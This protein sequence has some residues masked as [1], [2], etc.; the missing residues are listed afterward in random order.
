MST[1]SPGDGRRSFGR[2]SL[3]R[4]LGRGGMG[5]V[6]LADA[7]ALDGVVKR[8]ALKLI[9]L[10]QDG[11]Q[12]FEREARHSML[13]SHSNIVSV[14]DAGTQGSTG[15]LAMEW[16]DGIDLDH[17]CTVLGARTSPPFPEHVALFIVH[18]VLRALDHAHH[19]G[20]GAGRVE[21]VHRDV[22]T[23]NI[24]VSRDGDVK[25]T[26]FGIARSRLY[27]ATSDGIVR[28]KLR[29]M[30]PEQLHGR[31]VDPRTDL[32]GVGVVLHEL[33]TGQPLRGGSSLA[34][35]V[36]Q[37]QSPPPMLPAYVGSLARTVHAWLLAPVMDHRPASARHVLEFLASHGPSPDATAE[38]AMVCRAVIGASPEWS[39]SEASTDAGTLPGTRT[40]STATSSAPVAVR[41]VPR[42]HIVGAAMIA[43]LLLGAAG[44]GVLLRTRGQEPAP[45][46]A[47]VD[48]HAPEVA[49]GPPTHES[50]S[51]TQPPKTLP[52]TS[53]PTGVSSPSSAVTPAATTASRHSVEEL[54]DACPVYVGDDREYLDIVAL[55]YRSRPVVLDGA[56]GVV[57]AV[58]AVPVP[59]WRSL[60]R[61][62]CLGHKAFALIEDGTGGAISILG[63]DHLA[64]PILVEGIGGGEPR[65]LRAR[66]APDCLDL[67]IDKEKAFL[68]LDPRGPMAFTDACPG[69]VPWA[70]P[71]RWLV[72]SS[73][74]PEPIVID[75]DRRRV[76][77]SLGPAGRLRLSV[78]EA[79]AP[80]WDKTFPLWRG[81]ANEVLMASARDRVWIV[82]NADPG[83][84][85]ES[86]VVVDADSG[87]EVFALVHKQAYSMFLFADGDRVVHVTST[88]ICSH[89]AAT[90]AVVWCYGAALVPAAPP[91]RSRKTP[92]TARCAAMRVHRPRDQRSRPRHD[93]RFARAE[94][95][96]TPLSYLSGPCAARSAWTSTRSAGSTRA[97][98]RCPI[99]WREWLGRVGET[100][101][102]RDLPADLDAAEERVDFGL[103]ERFVELDDDVAVDSPE[104]REP[105]E[106]GELGVLLE[107]EVTP[108]PLQPREPVEGGEFVVDDETRAAADGPQ[109]LESTT[110][111]QFAHVEELEHAVDASEVGHGREVLEAGLAELEAAGPFELIEP[112]E[113][114]EVRVSGRA[115]KVPADHPQRRQ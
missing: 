30:A 76:A 52:K 42:A 75:A 61:M 21:I 115:G 50:S 82:A 63:V 11:A 85:L 87:D 45:T 110:V 13:L 2:Y 89:E 41:P 7:H 4:R 43:V 94:S 60:Q 79:G 25:L 97:A 111:H 27:A 54:V 46:P 104:A 29:F 8:V 47:V 9:P 14:F 57:T 58:E 74:Q 17:L 31:P 105:R 20:G 32:Y 38:V 37:A 71:P 106:A 48:A 49:L 83:G 92:R 19:V 65:S 95:R 26:D 35:F 69:A 93:A 91:P 86:I 80:L 70:P 101:V 59:G 36:T 62:E 112:L 81:R 77:A 5:E 3:I 10:D 33:L 56:S 40:A 107:F 100:L 6:W 64:T 16:V 68:D 44:T 90:G 15:Y 114:Q 113:V 73:R 78:T 1:A 108:D 66:V 24:L 51:P 84:V 67:P 103:R 88:S 39:S 53:T 34:E 28:G 72:L 109:T 18:R 22:S 99:R 96:T 55:E 102:D 98:A 23:H 12:Q